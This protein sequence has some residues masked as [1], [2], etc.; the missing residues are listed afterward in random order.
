MQRG[1]I[2]N[3]ELKN[4]IFKP[5]AQDNPTYDGY[6]NQELVEFCGEEA[7]G[8]AALIITGLFNVNIHE[9]EAATGHPRVDNDTRLAGLGKLARSIQ[10]NGAKACLQLAH[11][12][13]H[14]AP[15]DPEY[16]WR[17]VSRDGVENEHWFP[18]LF[19]QY[20]NNYPHKEYTID[21]IHELVGWYGD[22]A[23]RAKTAGFDMVEVH[24][25]NMHGLNTWLTPRMNKRKDEYGGSLEKRC[26][27][28]FEIIEDIQKKCGKKFPILVRLNAEDIVPGGQTIEDAAWIASELEKRGVAAINLA[29]MKSGSPMQTPMGEILKYAKPVKDA[30]SIP[31]MICGSMNKPEMGEKAIAEGSADY[32]GM[33]RQLYADPC[34]PKKVYEGRPED[35]RPCIR[36]N[37]CLNMGRSAFHGHLECTMNPQIGKE[38]SLPVLP[39]KKVKNIA[40][41]GA[42]PAGME[43]ALTA[44]ERG[45]KVTLFEKRKLGGRVNEASVPEFKADLRSLI[46]YFETQVKKS[47]IEV[48]MEEATVQN[49]KDFDAVIVATGAS[50]AVLKVPGSDT[51]MVGN[52]I[53]WLDT[54]TTRGNDIVIIGGG[55]VGIEVALTNAMAGRKVTVIEMMDQIMAGE[56]INVKMIYL[57][58]LKELKVTVLTGTGVKSIGKDSV[59]A[60]GPEGEIV[61]P[62]S[63]VLT[64]VGLK[65]DLTLRDEL[66]KIPGLE[67]YYAGDCERPKLIF[68]AIHSGFNTAR[69]I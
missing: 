38:D 60:Q 19:P 9:S 24:C 21:E 3:V 48:R 43:A 7:R 42:G 51:E 11:Y 63:D 56:N 16:G 54:K 55:S 41:A 17:C 69:L 15:A 25:A 39:A 27:I 49:L 29:C 47:S 33:A 53:D 14:G 37:E 45:H 61:I 34:W 8:G 20:G 36:C 46:T 67:V 26:R 6:V 4:R 64:S 13:S 59:T 22:G 52:A 28:V 12:G 58:M 40:V 1:K 2:G 68:D 66:D 10:D 30:I 35:I 31:L 18:I 62:A 23:L 50:K 5:A 32:I 44:A 57:N 65:P